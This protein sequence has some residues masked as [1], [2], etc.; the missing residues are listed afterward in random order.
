MSAAHRARHVWVAG[1]L[2][3]LGLGLSL[4]PTR[5]LAAPHGVFERLNAADR[6]LAEHAMQE[7]LESR[8]SGELRIWHN[9]LTGSSGSIIPL[10]TFKVETGHYCRDYRETAIAKRKMASRNLTACRNQDGVW[11]TTGR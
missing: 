9:H 3:V 10:R 5:L 6:R 1:S 2:V 11:T 7:T 4:Q 8:R